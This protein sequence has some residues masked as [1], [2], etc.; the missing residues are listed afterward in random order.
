MN[1]TTATQVLVVDDEPL[2]RSFLRQLLTELW[3]DAQTSE[4]ADGY[5]ALEHCRT[6]PV[7]VAFLDIQMPGMDGLQL[8]RELRALP[9]PPLVV[10]C[11]AYNQHAIRAFDLEAVDYLLKPVE[12]ERLAQCIQRLQQR[13]AQQQNT[14]VSLLHLQQLLAQL[15][16]GPAQTSITPAGSASAASPAGQ[17]STDH[18]TTEPLRWIKASLRDTVHL[19]DVHDVDYFL[20]EDK[21]TTVDCQGQQYLIRTPIA[22]LEQQLDPQLF[23]RIHRSTI[24]KVSSILKV[25]RDEFGHM[26]LQLKNQPTELAVSRACQHLFR[27]H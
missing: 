10:F 21:Y 26:T 15:Q 4:A 19:L 13:L 17:T 23:W 9:K 5:A 25:Q 1:Q 7:A 2:L 20:A 22:Q 8:L 3:P 14:A 16:P 12:E 27:Q 11:T 18:A 6:Q 24:V